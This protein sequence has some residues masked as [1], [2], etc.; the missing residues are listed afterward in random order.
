MECPELPALEAQ[1]PAADI[2]G[3][4]GEC[5]DRL[6]GDGV[7][8]DAFHHLANARDV[9]VVR[10][11]LGYDRLNLQGGSYGTQ[12]ALLAA[13]RSPETIRSVTLSPPI[14]PRENWVDGIPAGFAR[15][16]DRVSA[17]CADDP[18]CHSAVGDFDAAIA[19]QPR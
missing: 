11:A 6:A 1:D 18:A 7:D 12:V 16:L 14:D 19:A 13:E 2:E 9:D 3:A 4:L 8:L 5:R 15:A 10:R 17:V